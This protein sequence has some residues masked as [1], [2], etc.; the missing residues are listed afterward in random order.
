ME[1]RQAM[2]RLPKPRRQLQPGHAPQVNVEIHAVRGAREPG[3][4]K[5]G[6][7]G[8]REDAEICRLKE[9]HQR[10]PDGGIVINDHHK[11]WGHGTL[12]QLDKK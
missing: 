1:D 10:S 7:R 4:E 11:V 6:R 3:V 8:I 9:A 12:L 5:L 2:P